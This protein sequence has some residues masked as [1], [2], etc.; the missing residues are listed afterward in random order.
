MMHNYKKGKWSF[1]I[2]ACSCGAALAITPTF[3]NAANKIEEVTVEAQKKVENITETPLAVQAISG[4]QFQKYASFNL[5]DLARSVAGLSFDPGVQVDIRLRGTSTVAGAPVSLRTNIY[6]DAALIDQPR[7]ILDSQYD[8]QRFEILKGAQGTLYGKSSPTGTINIHTRDPNLAVIDGYIASSVAD[9]GTRNAQ[10]G[11]SLP[12]IEGKLGVRIAG[13]YDE[14]Q[15][16]Q[17]DVTTGSEAT[18]RGS[19]FR[20]TALWEPDDKFKARASYNYREKK[21][22]PWYTIDGV[23]D[24]HHYNFDDDK[25]TANNPDIDKFRDQ[26]AI[27]EL[28]YFIDSH[29]TLTSVTAYEDQNYTNLQDTDGSASV[30]G[31]PQKN[32]LLNGDIQFTQIPLR[33]QWQEDLRLAS[34]NNKFWDWQIGGYYHRNSTATRI[35]VQKFDVASGF[36]ANINTSFIGQSEEFAAYTHQTFKLTD[37]L[38]II[39][40]LR[41]QSFRAN[42]VQPTTGFGVNPATAQI[43]PSINLV[44]LGVLQAAG[45]P[46]SLQHNSA[47]PITGTLKA[48]YFL[49][50]DLVAYATIDRAFRTGSANLNIQGN[51]P[52]D[53]A[54][55]KSE[56]AKSAEVGLKGDFMD[57]RGRFAVAMFDQIY[58]NF[59]QDIQNLP[60]YD[61]AL[62]KADNLNSFV[63]N[64]KEAE[65]FGVESDLNYLLTDNWE[66]GI[67]AAYNN[68][69]FNDFK[70]NPCNGTAPLT[71]TNPYNTC[72]LSNKRLPLASRW[73][74]VVTS[75]F[76]LPAF[77]GIDWYFNT[78]INLKSNQVDKVTRATLSGYG[79]A[80][81]F[82]GLR[83]VQKIGWDVSLWIKNAFDKRVVTRIF[84]STTTNPDLR[85]LF[86]G[87]TFAMVTTNSPRQVGATGTYRF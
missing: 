72:D 10:F 45:I 79:T 86:P 81:F 25:I 35:F 22:N 47:Y 46:T 9:Y 85:A 82:T 12:L 20:F 11:I 36:G 57:H 52:T 26:L 37:D 34:E 50:P 1:W 69:K 5:Q 31:P 3:V 67:S 16:G 17:K 53:F 71:P 60:V 77:D 13:V 28:N 65:I 61:T 49:T 68:A 42:S 56:S 62:G 29:L 39:A 75:D 40:G 15:T 21:S 7:V 23:Q 8:I 73:A 14:T 58:T 74:G 2:A 44:N 38:N 6:L 66:V 78:L 63:A 4:D 80:D 32:L 59:Q 41:Y 27:L 70:N 84:N 24:G 48:Q 83:T 30:V 76:S 18:N 64:A 51:L 87:E 19:G 43:V 33:P 55:L 54:E